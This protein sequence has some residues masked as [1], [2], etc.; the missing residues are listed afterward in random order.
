MKWLARCLSQLNQRVPSVLDFGCGT[1]TAV[2]F[3]VEELS[4][5]RIIGVDVSVKS[6]EVARQTGVHNA[7]SSSRLASTIP[8]LR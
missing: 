5:K 7:Q 1:G 8:T 4:A 6:L 3:M 2:P